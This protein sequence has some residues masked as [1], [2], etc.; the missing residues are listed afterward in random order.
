MPQGSP[1]GGGG[2]G[3]VI[4]LCQLRAPIRAQDEGSFNDVGSKVHSLVFFVVV[5]VRKFSD[6]C[7]K[8]V[9]KVGKI[10]THNTLCFSVL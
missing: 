4:E 2:V 7:K 6:S 9:K 10:F 8:K 3:R 1:C 5:K